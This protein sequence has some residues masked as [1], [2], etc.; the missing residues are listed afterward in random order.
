MK[1][2]I[3][4]VAMSVV[5][6][7][8]LG[9]TD[10]CLTSCTQIKVSGFPDTRCNGVYT[11]KE[12]TNVGEKPTLYFIEAQDAPGWRFEIFY[13]E[14]D[15]KY[16]VHF[17]EPGKSLTPIFYHSKDTTAYKC[18]EE[19]GNNLQFETLDGKN[20]FT[21]KTECLSPSSTNPPTTANSPCKPCLKVVGADSGLNGH[22]KLKATEDT[23]CKKDGCLYQKSGTAD[24][25]CFEAGIHTVME[26]DDCPR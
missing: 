15:S 18:L 12:N 9:E 3:S 17:L 24:M 21:V 4:L 5:L 22:Y 20:T 19:I 8:V 10:K 13:T 14:T 7:G 25:Y 16:K 2:V 1:L 11:P 26:V 23:R 6:G